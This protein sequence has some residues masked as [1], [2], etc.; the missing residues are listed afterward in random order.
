MHSGVLLC[1]SMRV[2]R[3]QPRCH[4]CAATIDV[5]PLCAVCLWL[6]QLLESAVVVVPL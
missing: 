5:S 1:S 6:R 3:S 4:P 2:R